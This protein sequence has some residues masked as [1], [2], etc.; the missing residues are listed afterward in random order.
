MKGR[1]IPGNQWHFAVTSKTVK[2]SSHLCKF[3]HRPT[4]KE[5]E[6]TEFDKKNWTHLRYT[7]LLH[8]AAQY[9]T[10]NYVNVIT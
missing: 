8:T 2:A 7:S 4:A 5:S 10:L 6:I 3:Y 1:L 9:T